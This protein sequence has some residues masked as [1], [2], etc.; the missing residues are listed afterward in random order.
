MKLY[1]FFLILIFPATFFLSQT[2]VS[3]NVYNEN[4][5]PLSGVLIV[6]I[7]S[8][9]QTLTD[10]NGHFFISASLGNELR[11]VRQN[12]E[13]VDMKLQTQNFYTPLKF[14][15][16]YLP[17]E[18]E[19]VVLN[20]KPTGNLKE[21]IKHYGAPKQDVELNKELG[22]YNRTYSSRQVM[23]P[24]R[25]EFV[26]PKGPGFETEKIGYQW[27]IEDLQ[28]NLE[29]TLSKEYFKSLGLQEYQ[30]FSFMDFVFKSFDTK[31]MRRFGRITSSDLA[32]FQGEAEKQLPLYLSKI[33]IK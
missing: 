9:T 22:K 2:T 16:K 3:G 20:Y 24:K 25:G 23:K 18:I 1:L 30:I 31:E 4:Q 28:I 6:N 17:K 13:R 32:R 8:H 26:Q 10:I 27:K 19:V 15:M 5:V 12:Y 21:D 7:D 11:F 33:N 14:E 29:K